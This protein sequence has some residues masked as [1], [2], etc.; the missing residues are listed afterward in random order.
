MFEDIKVFV[1]HAL[2]PNLIRMIMFEVGG[3]L[4]LKFD[5]WPGS[6]MV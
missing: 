3:G 2:P 4:W 1:V 6:F 5:V